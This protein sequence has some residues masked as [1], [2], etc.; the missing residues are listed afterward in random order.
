MVS[1]EQEYPR[2]GTY[3]GMCRLMVDMYKCASDIGQHFD[4]I[5][6]LLADIVRLP[7]WSV[8]V[9]H[10]VDLN[11]VIRPTLQRERISIG[12]ATR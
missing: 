2:K 9:H 10:Y 1:T 5:L 7:Q 6:K 4:L 11:I 3:G 8:R 12:P